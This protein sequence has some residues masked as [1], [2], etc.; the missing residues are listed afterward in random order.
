MTER[1]H[2]P[3]RDEDGRALNPQERALEELSAA[4]YRQRE[5]MVHYS[6]EVQG[7]P[8]VGGTCDEGDPCPLHAVTAAVAGLIVVELDTR[9]EA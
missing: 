7:L 3:G 6:L 1:F 4:Q 2:G 8:C 9:E 5:R